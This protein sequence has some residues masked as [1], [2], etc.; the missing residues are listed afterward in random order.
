MVYTTSI[1]D[2][3]KYIL[4]HQIILVIFFL[5]PI[6][7]T[8]KDYR[9]ID[10]SF[11][12]DKSMPI[13]KTQKK[14]RKSDLKSFDE[15]S[16]Y[17]EK[18]DGLFT[19][20]F[21]EDKDI[22]YLSLKPSQLN[23]TYLANLTRQSGDGAY[24]DASN[25]MN[26]YPF[27]LQRVNNIIQLVRLNVKYRADEN[28]AIYRAVKDHIPNSILSTA[29]ILCNPHPETG[30]VLINAN[31]F[32]ITDIGNVSRSGSNYSFDR[33]NSHYEY[34]QSFPNNSEI[35]V[36]LHFT[37]S[38][39]NRSHTLADSRSMLHRYHFSWSALPDSAYSPRL[40]DD[41]IGHFTTMYRDYSNTQDE[42]GYVRYI[43][44]WRLEK[45]Y[46][47][48]D[49][50]EPIKPIVFW[51]ENTI[52]EELRQAVR[53]GIETW[54]PAFEA[55]GFKNAII[56]KQMPDDANWDPADV[57]YNVI[58]W[59]I[60]P[61]SAYAVGP[62]R[63]NLFTGE[64][65]DADIRISADFVRFYANE[66]DEFITPL[67]DES[68]QNT[69]NHYCDYSTN[70]Q[71]NMSFTWNYQIASNLIQGNAR[72]LKQFIH[73][74]IV[75]LV[76]H[77]VGHTLGLRHNFKAS[78]AFTIE[79]LSDPQ[80]T[81]E[82]GVT[83]SV[84]DYN[85]IN[86]LDGGVTYFQTQP[87][88]YD[89]LA[90]KYAYG[91]PKPNSNISESQFLNDVAKQTANSW[92]HY[93]TD[94]DAIG[95]STRGIDPLC[96]TRDAS[97][98]PIRHSK[99]QIGF[100]KKLWN[101][102]PSD[103]DKEI[104]HFPKFRR[105]FNQ[106]FGEYYKAIRNVGKFIGGI[107]HSRHHVNDNNMPPFRVVSAETQRQ[108]LQFFDEMI[109]NHDAFEF[110]P[111]LLNLL[112]PERFQNF[113]G[114]AW[115]S[116]N[117]DY[118]IHNKIKSLQSSSLYRLFN[119]RTIR[120]VHDNELKVKGNDVFSLNELFNH[121][122]KSIWS[123]LNN[124]NSISS[125]RREL[126]RLYIERMQIILLDEENYF[127]NDAYSLARFN[128]TEVLNGI[129]VKLNSSNLDDYS[130]AHLREM[131]NKI[132]TILNSNIVRIK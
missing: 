54:Q 99:L 58:R 119:Y 69:N 68:H 121:V 42:S 91:N 123:E 90:I 11:L 104:N 94:E 17:C 77:E 126:Q 103:L 106:G 132:S 49:L 131:S 16:E 27:Q 76:L 84:M 111:E 71:E 115:N 124:D 33:S 8:G 51:L 43:N 130:I 61:N 116:N 21:D 14:E 100:V 44:R 24:Y 48:Y 39:Y 1:K 83:S 113:S 30:E 47:L 15:V 86:L 114:N 66:Y 112:A 105:I 107:H 120:R 122:Q 55:I 92:L 80:F 74:S 57:R 29:T 96:S 25:L 19:F 117:L 45:K 108:A 82:N 81:Q 59:I 60:Q 5:L 53:D 118:P 70:L 125:F 13:E 35:D 129:N 37:S 3:M 26:D 41:R 78:S 62:S 64:L 98:E 22:A 95:S 2:S 7:L 88:L 4:N 6:N 56:A 10:E 28:K 67:K 63:A 46:P 102:I 110:S 89:Y 36:T 40:A 52:P 87:G 101:K 9:K 50:S 32:F 93:G 20:Y 38:K 34:L 85:L 65:Y 73:D 31:A 127:P 109:F 97:S 12:Y 128:L 72:D 18:I 23:Q 79:Q 75:D